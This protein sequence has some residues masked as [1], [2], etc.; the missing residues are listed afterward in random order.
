MLRYLWTLLLIALSVQ[1]MAQTLKVRL[2]PETIY[3]GD[4]FQLHV[5]VEGTEIESVTSH[6]SMPTQTLG[7]STQVTVVNGHMTA[8][9][10]LTILPQELGV[11]RLESLEVVTTS[12]KTLTYRQPLSVTVQA[13][14]PDR[15]V[16]ID[17]AM[18]PEAPLPGDEVSVQITIQAPALKDSNGKWCSP[19]LEQDFFGRIQERI[20]NLSFNAATGDD[21]PLRLKGEPRLLSREVEGE[22]MIWKIQIDYLAVRV[23]EQ[24]FPAPIIKDKRYELAQGGQLTEKRCATIGDPLTVC[25]VAP[26]EEGKP[27]GF[28]GAVAADF[29]AK[30]SL[31]ALNVKVG[32]PVKLTIQFLTSATTEQIRAPQLPRLQGFRVYGDPIRNTFEGGCSFVYNLR[33]IQSGLLE[34]PSLNFAWFE[35]QTRAYQVTHTVAVPLYAHPSAQLVLMG[36]DGEA[37]T[38]TLPPALRLEVTSP[39]QTAAAP[40]ALWT[41]LGGAL[42]GVLMRWGKHLWTV[43]QWVAQTCFLRSPAER[44]RLALKRAKTPSESLAAM[45][46]WAGKPALTA[47][48]LRRMLPQTPTAEAAVAA[49]AVLEQAVYSHEVAFTDA[50]DQLVKLLPSLKAYAPSTGHKVGLFLLLAFLLL[51][52]FAQAEEDTFLREQATYVTLAATTPQDY[53]RAANLWMQLTA[54]TPDQAALLNAASCALF[55][56]YPSITEH[57][58]ERYELAFGSDA[59]CQRLLTAAAE[60]TGEPPFWGRSLFKPHYTYS[61]GLRLNALCVAFALL[62]VVSAMRWKP[63]KGVRCLVLLATLAIGVSV[64]MSTF[65]L[66]YL[67]TLSP[68]PETSAEEVQP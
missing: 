16:T 35:K 29:E 40:W 52:G 5:S 47:T 30:V 9:R 3:A 43:C 53:A 41:L 24:T 65:R 23:G 13:L 28:T 50:R 37:L 21:S 14:T 6:F 39:P 7:Q 34:V 27:E 2:A 25:V 31:D 10:A 42:L 66:H 36:E 64:V 51:P 67:P 49:M 58:M 60:R 26:P 17:V 56:R 18:T 45:R 54:T 68:L 38:G 8:G 32:D 61:Y 59:D 12:G 57:L 62:M 22:T 46:Q 44:A 55:A 63:L 19:F 15:D 33:P 4:A 1:V 48:E 11:C 20:P